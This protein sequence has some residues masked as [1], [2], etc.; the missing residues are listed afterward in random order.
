MR[1][2]FQLLEDLLDALFE[3][4]WIRKPGQV[5]M[6]LLPQHDEPAEQSPIH[7]CPDIAVVVMEG[8]GSDRLFRYLECVRPR[9]AWADL[10]RAAPVITLRAEGPRTIRINPVPKAMQVEAMRLD[11]TVFDMNA[12]PIAGS[13]VDDRAGHA[14]REWGFVYIRGD[15][16]VRFRRQVLRVEVLPVDQCRQPT[17]GH[18]IVRDLAVL[19][20]HVSHAI[21]RVHNRGRDVHVRG[22]GAVVWDPFDFEINVTSCHRSFLLLLLFTINRI[23]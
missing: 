14:A 7:V 12:Q 9:L 13:C 11:I 1:P 10:I 18:L 21:P 20:S 5:L 3:F 16:L 6:L 15:E 22:D 2:A 17:C 8:P 23:R 19:V 4:G